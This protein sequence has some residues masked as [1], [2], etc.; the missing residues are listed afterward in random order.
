MIVRMHWKDGEGGCWITPLICFSWKPISFTGIIVIA[1]ICS[2]VEAS[3]NDN[4]EKLIQKC[5]IQDEIKN[6]LVKNDYMIN[7]YSMGLPNPRSI[8][9]SLMI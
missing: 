5:I 8:V 1:S 3:L 4:E 9:K 7:Q 6:D 2:R